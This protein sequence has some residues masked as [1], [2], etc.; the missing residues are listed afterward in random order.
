VV[1]VLHAAQ[2]DP[3]LPQLTYHFCEAASGGDVNKAVDYAVRAAERAT[4]LLA[5]EEAANHYERGL[6]ALEAV[7]PVEETRRC[8]LLISLGEAQ[9]ASGTTVF[10][11]TFLRAAELAR[12]IGSPDQFARAA[13]APFSVFLGGTGV[14]DEERIGVLEEALALLGDG[15]SA[16]R[17][18]V[19]TLLGGELLFAPQ[20]ERRE[21]LCREAIE[22][23]RR[24]GDRGAL[25]FA[26]RVGNT[27]LERPEDPKPCLE[28]LDEVVALARRSKDKRMEAS[29]RMGRIAYLIRLADTESIDQEIEVFSRLAEELRQPTHLANAATMRACRA[30]WQGQLAE[31]RRLSWEARSQRLRF[32]PEMAAQ[33]FGLLLYDLRRKQGR[34]AEEIPVIVKGVER[35]PV[36]PV[37]RCLLACAYAETGCEEDARLQ[38]EKLAENDFIVLSDDLLYLSNLGL[39]SDVC[40]TLRDEERAVPLYDRLRLYKGRYLSW[41][42]ILVRGSA[43]RSLGLLAAAMRR[44]D[45]AE[46]HFEEAIEVDR[47]MRARGW[48]PR[49]QCDYARMLL[50]R[51]ELGDRGKALNLL[52]EAVKTSQELGLKGWLDMALELK[53]RA[54]GV[55]RGSITTSIDLVASSVGDRCPDLAPHAAPDGT[56]TLMFSDMEG[57]TAMTERLGD[58]KAR[59]VIRDHNAI[60]REELKAH[61]G[62]EVELQGD[63]FLLA[64]GSARQGLL[65]AIEIQRAFAVYNETHIDEPIH[66]RIGLHTGE[67]LK[68]ADKFFGKTVILAARIAAQARGG[69]ILVSSLIKQL[70]QSVG[71]LRFGTGREVDL[72]GISERQRVH[73]VEWE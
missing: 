56:V 32:N 46:R 21:Q 27:V 5:Y 30:L 2:L 70:T 3:R 68:D 73:K 53:L 10:R 12:R 25:A 34:L 51:N 64:F 14:P 54:Q 61:G 37:W 50:D 41:H 11:Q 4:E 35:F 40:A 42:V 43:A 55:D 18:H 24:V 6:S 65:C 15:D 23:A 57:F 38:L 9:F 52:A 31:A 28:I 20:P 63:G 59:D 22:I 66:V 33:W 58:L 49:T 39:L 62:Y 29:G 60:V 47:Q 26:L 72:K 67:V 69:E 48:L 36:I 1:E 8:E 71:D 16:L 19:M 17:A 7:E 44:W 13:I 45:D